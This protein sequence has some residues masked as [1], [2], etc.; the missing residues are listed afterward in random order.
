MRIRVYRGYIVAP[1]AQQKLFDPLKSLD[2]FEF[3]QSEEGLEL[4]DF[5]LGGG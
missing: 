4:Q 1:K 2:I 3:F 5:S